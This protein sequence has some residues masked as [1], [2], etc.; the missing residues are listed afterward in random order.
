MSNLSFAILIHPFFIPLCM[1]HIA[2]LL[3][4]NRVDFST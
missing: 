1:Y 3:Y 4:L 2:P